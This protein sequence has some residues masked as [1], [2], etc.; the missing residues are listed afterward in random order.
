MM[1]RGIAAGI[2]LLGTL[3]APAM[4][5]EPVGRYDVS[6]TNPGN[7]GTYS[8]SATV[9]KTGDTYRVVWQIGSD[10]YVG[11]GVGNS[12]FIAV[13]YRFGNESGLALYGANGRGWKGVWAYSG[14][15]QLGSEV[16]T[17]R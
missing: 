16:W 12:E 9:E 5:D 8:G 13:S 10:R 1:I 3:L 2:L 4:A 14:G 15:Q 17:R 7:R 6:G 11:T